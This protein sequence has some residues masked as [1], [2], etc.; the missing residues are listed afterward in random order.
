M[1]NPE[2]S[3]SLKEAHGILKSGR[4]DPP[5][6]I[7]IRVDTVKHLVGKMGASINLESA[8]VE[9]LGVHSD[10]TRDITHPD[11][12]E[13][14]LKS[15]LETVLTDHLPIVSQFVQYVRV[16]VSGREMNFINS[17]IRPRKPSN[18]EL[19][20]WENGLLRVVY[21]ALDDDEN[22]SSQKAVL[23]DE[24]LVTRWRESSLD[25]EKKDAAAFIDTNIA[26]IRSGGSPRE[27]FT[28]VYEGPLP[29]ARTKNSN[30]PS[31]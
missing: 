22:G 15:R 18:E 4:Q 8:L 20:F 5:F 2:R 25:E 14:I 31:M 1:T 23:T 3:D 26:F 6:P 27:S 11:S 10:E 21:E 13:S 19:E 7:V 24:E 16:P 17:E 28:A 9:V 12:M 29:Q 30:S